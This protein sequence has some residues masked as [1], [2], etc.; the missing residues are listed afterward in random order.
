MTSHAARRPAVASRDGEA[1]SNS[2]S[3]DT[4]AAHLEWYRGIFANASECLLL[5]ST[6][7]RVIEANPRVEEC[8]SRRGRPRRGE[9]IWAARCWQG[10]DDTADRLEAAVRGAASGAR[11]R[12]ETP[13]SVP[14]FTRTYEW[15]LTPIPDDHGAIGMI[16]A[17]GR[18]LTSQKQVE[19]ALHDS[20]EGLRRMIAASGE[21]IILVGEDGRIA[22]FNSGAERLFG[23]TAVEAIGQSLDALVVENLPVGRR[24]LRGIRN[25]KSL[26]GAYEHRHVIGR[27]KDGEVFPAEATLSPLRGARRAFAV[28]LYDVS[29]RWA[30]EEISIGAL[31]AADGIADGAGSKGSTSN[32]AREAVLL[33]DASARLGASLDAGRLLDA[34]AELL[35]PAIA[36]FC[37]IEILG[38][39][40]QPRRL[41]TVHRDRNRTGLTTLFLGYPRDPDRPYIGRTAVTAG[42]TEYVERLSDTRLH[43]LA[44]DEAYLAA[45]RALNPRSYVA[46]PLVARG[47]TIGVVTVVRD[48][49]MPI[50]AG[51]DVVLI[52]RLARRAALAFDHALAHENALRAIQQRDE[53][54]SI[55]THDLRSPLGAI[56]LN[57]Q[58]LE[59]LT[60]GV[61][62]TRVRQ[63]LSTMHE[64]VQWMD[65]LINDLVDVASIEAGRLSLEVTPVDPALLVERALQQ[66]DLAASS[67]ML[68]LRAELP[69]ELP[70]LTGDGDRLHQVLSNLLS[71]AVRL[72]PAGGEIVVRA[73][74][75]PH[76]MTFSVR[77]TGP[78]IPANEQRRIFDR[79]VHIRRG[80]S[81]RG[82]GLG[83]AIAKG[84]VEA[85]GGRIWVESAPGA[86]SCFVFSLP[87]A[88]PGD[89]QGQSVATH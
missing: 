65:R 26:G 45:L 1:S 70:V 80:S 69:H 78:G 18:D 88:G 81:V 23:Y 15:S 50:F 59:E 61:G 10:C 41:A 68:R 83:L 62:D 84:I 66:F 5:L 39:A 40:G 71:N 89:L 20:R 22:Q 32:A 7:G 77:D 67:G 35:V 13:V 52:E 25:P 33:A 19:D 38:E 74:A 2:Q 34:M 3:R 49:T 11:V 9:F 48:G 76:E 6:D 79:F 37:V 56:T 8:L 28:S 44:Q 64:S 82:T 42:T 12:V 47:A 16:L 17:E 36:S 14:R 43:L 85:H 86:G 73:E 51:D 30:S 4:R 87:L 72:T 21:A 63:M 27:R 29:A 58:A 24:R 31:A 54:M 60:R 46:T 55:V 57:A 53:V 75:D